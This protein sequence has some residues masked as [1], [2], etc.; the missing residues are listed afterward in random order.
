M[1]IIGG[2]RLSGDRCYNL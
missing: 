1:V 2:K